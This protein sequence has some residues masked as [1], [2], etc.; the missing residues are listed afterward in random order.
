MIEKGTDILCAF[1]FET[2]GEK[3]AACSLNQVPAA[4]EQAIS[5]AS[6]A[7]GESNPR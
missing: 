3:K 5:S 6:S 1:L 7:S 4:K 2:F